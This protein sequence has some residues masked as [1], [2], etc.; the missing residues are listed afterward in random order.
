MGDLLVTIPITS[1]RA[2]RNRQHQG[3][4]TRQRNW[5]NPFEEVLSG[6]LA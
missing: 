3:G 1:R 5:N 6:H 2:H 4:R